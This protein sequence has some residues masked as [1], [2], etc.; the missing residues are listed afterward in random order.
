[1]NENEA[2]KMDPKDLWKEEAF[3]DRKVGA[4]RRLTP[5]NPDGTTDLSRKAVFIGEAALMTP[6]GSIPLNFEIPA[7]DL[8]AAVAGYG[9]ALQKAYADALEELNEMRR[10]QASRIVVPGAETTSKL[11]LP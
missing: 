6:A 1:M 3:T 8:G 10:K 7:A 4:I 9:P 5:V 11:K 2:P